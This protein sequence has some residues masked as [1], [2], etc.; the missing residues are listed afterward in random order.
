MPP[1]FAR[2]AMDT[3]AAT[4]VML[5][6]TAYLRHAVASVEILSDVT[7]GHVEHEAGLCRCHRQ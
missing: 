2:A 6:A 1:I 7:I 4:M 3:L 5:E